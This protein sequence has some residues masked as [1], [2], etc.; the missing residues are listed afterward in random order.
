MKKIELQSQE[1]MTICTLRVEILTALNEISLKPKVELLAFSIVVISL[2]KI[3]H[4]LPLLNGPFHVEYKILCH[5]V[6]STAEAE[7]V[8]LFL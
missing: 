2:P 3:L 6:T 5:I 7:T 8:G 1:K 4:P